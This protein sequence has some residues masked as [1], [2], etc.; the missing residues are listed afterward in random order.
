VQVFSEHNVLHAVR[1][2]TPA[3]VDEELAGFLREA[4]AVGEQQHRRR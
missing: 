1:L 3:D 4:Y 2:N